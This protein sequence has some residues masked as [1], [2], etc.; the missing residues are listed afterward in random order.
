MCSFKKPF[1]TPTLIGTFVVTYFSHKGT[2]SFTHTLTFDNSKDANEFAENKLAQSYF[3]KI[4]NWISGLYNPNL[5]ITKTDTIRKKAIKGIL[6]F[7]KDSQKTKYSLVA[8]ANEIDMFYLPLIRTV[9]ENSTANDAQS[10]CLLHA[11]LEKQ[12]KNMV[13]IDNSLPNDTTT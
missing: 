8:A 11:S 12:I 4:S 13:T 10:T 5:E 9:Y 7:L 2:N 6:F 1:V 3:T